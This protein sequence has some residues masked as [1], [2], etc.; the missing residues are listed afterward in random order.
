MVDGR[1]C[2]ISTQLLLFLV[3]TESFEFSSTL[4][5][6]GVPLLS[7]SF[8]AIVFPPWLMDEVF[9]QKEQ[10]AGSKCLWVSQLNESKECEWINPLSTTTTSACQCLCRSLESARAV[11]KSLLPARDTHRTRFTITRSMRKW[12]LLSSTSMIRNKLV[13]QLMQ[14][15]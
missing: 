12:L 3:R 2:R 1:Y 10:K 7:F 6:I 14:L 9:L 8:C 4:W 11:V 5:S 13:I 15:V